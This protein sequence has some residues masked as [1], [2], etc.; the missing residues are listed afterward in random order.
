[1]SRA[2]QTT[3]R[4]PGADPGARSDGQDRGTGPAAPPERSTGSGLDVRNL[5]KRF[6]STTVLKGVD[7]EFRTGEVHAL[8]GANGAG[9]STLLSCLS[10]AHRPSSGE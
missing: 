10:G 7:L 5:T 1:M 8:L 2:S 9:K 6:G 4:P 3:E